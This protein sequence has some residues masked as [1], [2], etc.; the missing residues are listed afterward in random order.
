MYPEIHTCTSS[1]LESTQQPPTYAQQPLSPSLDT[2]SIFPQSHTLLHLD[3]LPRRSARHRACATATATRHGGTAPPPL[4]LEDV[5]HACGANARQNMWERYEAS[6]WQKTPNTISLSRKKASYA[7]SGSKTLQL[8]CIVI[9]CLFGNFQGCI[10]VNDRVWG[11]VAWTRH[12]NF[13]ASSWGQLGTTNIDDD[14]NN[15]ATTIRLG[16][17][18]L[19]RLVPNV[20]QQAVHVPR[21]SGEAENQDNAEQ[22]PNNN[23]FANFHHSL[24]Y[25]T[26]RVLGCLSVN[27]GKRI[28]KT[29]RASPSLPT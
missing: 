24:D 22:E 12:R 28:T 20:S 25:Y 15:N 19:A 10:G 26:G 4:Y 16:Y 2:S 7:G 9:K 6:G 18:G 14:T 23:A 29:E 5:N 1:I 8:L 27:S 21:K 17:R 11:H 3:S 13:C